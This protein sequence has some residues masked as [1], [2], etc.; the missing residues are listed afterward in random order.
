MIKGDNVKRN[1][2]SLSS[3]DNWVR[4]EEYNCFVKDIY[5]KET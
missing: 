5:F 4:Q 2:K 1:T 3:G